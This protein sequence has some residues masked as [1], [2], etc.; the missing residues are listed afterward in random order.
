MYMRFNPYHG[1]LLAERLTLEE[2]RVKYTEAKLWNF[3]AFTGAVIPLSITKDDPFGY[4]QPVP[5]TLPKFINADIRIV[6]VEYEKTNLRLSVTLEAL[7]EEL[8]AECKRLHN[9]A[10]DFS[11]FTFAKM[12]E[13]GAQVLMDSWTSVGQVQAKAANRAGVNSN[14]WVTVSQ[15]GDSRAYVLT[16]AFTE[17]NVR[18]TD[19]LAA[20]RMGCLRVNTQIGYDDDGRIVDIKRLDLRLGLT[21]GGSGLQECEDKYYNPPLPEMH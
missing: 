14:G 10:Y 15:Q 18:K 2:F 3:D 6:S 11:E 20:W 17:S 12:W 7:S 16:M 13:R 21:E 5:S 8:F 4:N 1:G 9:F 19:L